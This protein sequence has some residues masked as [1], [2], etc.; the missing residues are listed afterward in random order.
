MQFLNTVNQYISGKEYANKGIRTSDGTLAYVTATGVTKQFAS[1]EDAGTAGA[2]CPNEFVD[3]DK[4]W[5]NLGFP[6]GSLMVTGQSCG[7]E[8][9]YVRGEPPATD[10]DWKFYLQNNPD[11]TQAGLTTEQQATDHWNNNGKAEGRAPNA[12][13][14]SSMG[15][16]GK[17]GYID[18]DTVFHAV[19]PTYANT[20][21]TFPTRSNLTGTAMLD[22][23]NPLPLVKYGDPLVLMQNNQTASLTSSSLL[24]FG[25]EA[26]NVFLR[27]PPGE[28]LTGQPVKVGDS[29]CISSSSS[30]YTTDCGWWGCKVGTINNQMQLL[31]DTGGESPSLF[32]IVS[33][34][35]AGTPLRLSD[36]FTFKSIPQM[37]KANLD[38]N[39]SVNCTQGQP[40]G[41][42]AGIYRYS[43]NNEMNYYPTPDVASSW[44]SNWGNAVDADCSTYDF[45]PTLTKNNAAN[46]SKGNTVTCNSGKEPQGGVRG[47]IYRYVDD[48]TLRWYSKPA[49]GSR[50]EPKWMNPK[51][52]DC[53]TYITGAAMTDKMDG[54]AAKELV[55]TPKFAYVSN[56]IMMFGTTEADGFLFSFQLT[57]YNPAC[58]ID[59][60]K[61]ICN[62]SADCIGFV[63]APSNNSWQMI[64]SQSSAGDYKITPTMQDVYVRDAN[65]DLNDDS[66]EPGPVSF[67]KGSVL[68][69][70]PKGADFG[71]GTDQC[72]VVQAPKCKVK[73]YVKKAT[74]IVDEFPTVEYRGDET[75]IMKKKTDEYRQV[76]QGIRKLEPSV[77]LEQQYKDMTVF[78][79]QNKSALIIWSILSVSILGFVFFRMKS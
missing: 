17:V 3:V 65:V 60:L 1:L 42:P 23:T 29:V 18:V 13:I 68:S 24:Q 15:M 43:G 4:T 78:D 47:G 33:T 49:L 38:V 63:Q 5:Q 45:G 28:D 9:T 72:K 6:I 16:V 48:N 57:N 44:N 55:E 59:N 14:L 20:Y 12:T 26:T 46:L 53:T 27:P 39:A 62:T 34:K 22:C 36:T 58:V 10:F 71:Q 11:L 35:A 69:N 70:Y 64:T 67:I 51:V 21:T 25:T 37:N 77:T 40:S 54:N 73:N 74:K 76:L 79:S 2:N 30:S 7:N 61:N 66:C 56:G 41:M 31:F 19:Q 8:G 52:I 50:W 75:K 32:T